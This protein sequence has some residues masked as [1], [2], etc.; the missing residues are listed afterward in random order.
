MIILPILTTLLVHLFLNGSENVLFEL[1]SKRVGAWNRVMNRQATER[2]PFKAFELFTNQPHKLCQ[3][4][5]VHNVAG[6]DLVEAS[7]AVGLPTPQEFPVTPSL[8]VGSEI[9]MEGPETAA[10][11]ARQLGVAARLK[12]VIV[13]KNRHWVE[14][15]FT[16][17]FREPAAFRCCR[18]P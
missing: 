1:G 8:F 16:F 12:E 18:T 10:G 17:F 14:D 11:E 13:K 5:R 6:T 2:G 4:N 9:T 3:R 7:W 15:R